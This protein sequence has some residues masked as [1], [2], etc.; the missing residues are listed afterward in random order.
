I[1]VA[2]AR[3]LEEAGAAYEVELDRE[4]AIRRA[5]EASGP[6]DIVLVAGKGHE[7]HQVIGGRLIPHSDIECLRRLGCTPCT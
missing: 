6:G 5:L 3:G 4:L 7:K 2:V 1:A